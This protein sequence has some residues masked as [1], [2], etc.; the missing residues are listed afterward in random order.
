MYSWDQEIDRPQYMNER[1]LQMMQS[2]DTKSLN[3]GKDFDGLL[4]MAQQIGWNASTK[5]NKFLG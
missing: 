3:L 5:N 1:L 2:N 4:W